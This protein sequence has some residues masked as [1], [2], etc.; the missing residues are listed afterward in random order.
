MRKDRPHV[1][2]RVLALLAA[3]WPG[4][5]SAHPTQAVTLQVI[6]APTGEFRASLSFD[7]LAYALRKPSVDAANEEMQALLDGPRPTLARALA[8]A[9]DQLRR[10]VVVRTDAGDAAPS[11][12]KLPGLPEVDAALARHVVPRILMAGDIAFSGT[13]PAAARTISIRLPYV[14]GEAVHVYAVP[15]GEGEGQLVAAGEYSNVVTFKLRTGEA[16][17]RPPS[18][19]RE[20]VTGGTAVAVALLSVLWLWRRPWHRR[21]GGNPA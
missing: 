8:V 16:S 7:L 17:P 5:I 2:R 6:V 10:E 9:N 3:L 1:A 14:L 12:W 4:A 15:G 13:L 11:G 21:L 18:L 20:A 19:R